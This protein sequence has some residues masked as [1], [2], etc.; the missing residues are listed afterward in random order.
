MPLAIDW[1]GRTAGRRAARRRRSSTCRTSQQTT[2]AGIAADIRRPPR[3]LR[4][5]DGGA[6]SGRCSRSG[7]AWAA[8][9]RSWRRRSG[10][11]WPGSIGLLRH[12]RRAVAQRRAGAGRRWPATIASPVLGLFGGADAGIP[13]DG[14]RGLRRGLDASRRRPPARDLPGRAAQLL[15]PQG[16][17]VRGER[18]APAALGSEVARRSS[19]RR[20]DQRAVRRRAST[21]GVRAG[22]AMPRRDD[23]AA[24]PWPIART[25]DADAERVDGRPIVRT[26]VAGV[27]ATRSTTARPRAPADDAIPGGPCRRRRRRTRPRC[28]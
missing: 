15:R 9:C 12:A 4:A 10:S 5:P 25:V 21:E 13:A 26:A 24:T 2:W 14:D 11:A 8:G 1:F 28:G 22:D 16:G 6:A 20:R 17:R 27:S 19:A 3:T 7:S 23:G 18:R